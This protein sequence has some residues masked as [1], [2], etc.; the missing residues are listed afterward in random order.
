M[1]R[2]QRLL[3]FLRMTELS[4]QIWRIER[5]VRACELAQRR[6]LALALGRELKAA[7]AAPDPRFYQTSGERAYRPWGEGTALAWARIR[8][9]NPEVQACGIALWLAVAYHET[10][11]STVNASQS[12]HRRIIRISRALKASLAAPDEASGDESGGL[13]DERFAARA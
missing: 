3:L 7:S 13:L 10:A 4:R 5:I 11:G 12:I 1:T 8:S 6:R 9:G 2:I